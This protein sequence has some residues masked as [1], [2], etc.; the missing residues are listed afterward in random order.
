MKKNNIYAHRNCWMHKNANIESDISAVCTLFKK[1]ESLMQQIKAINNQTIN[2]REILLFQ[3]NIPE[4]YKIELKSP[5]KDFFDEIMISKKNVGVWG[6]F[7]YA[8]SAKGKYICLFDDDTIP[9]SRWLENC[10]MN[11][12]KHEGVYGTIGIVMTE[13]GRYPFDGH[14][15]VGWGNPYS[16][17]AEVDFAGHSWFFKREWLNYMFDGTEEFQNFKYVAEDMC[18]SVQCAKHNIKTFVPP[19][20]Y[21]NLDFWGSNPELADRFGKAEGSISLNI[22]NYV[23]MNKAIKIFEK[24]NWSPLYK[25]D[26]SYVRH[27]L[28][29]IKYEKFIFTLRKLV[30]KIFRKIKNI[31]KKVIRQ[32]H[33]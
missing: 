10:Y 11:M 24:D 14:Y 18:L 8:R 27:L 12:C 1:P 28:Q 16:K 30:K 20:P 33:S 3:D 31:T 32:E 7:N 22:N 13:K 6:R 17:K 29:S 2:P 9:G 5:L 26:S 23:L 21:R 4:N 15:R 19:H 25:R